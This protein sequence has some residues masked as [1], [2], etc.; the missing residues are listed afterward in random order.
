MRR[1][2]L[3]DL[4]DDDDRPMLFPQVWGHTTGKMWITSNGTAFPAKFSF[5]LVNVVNRSKILIQCL[6]KASSIDTAKQSLL[7]EKRNVAAHNGWL[8]FEFS[9]SQVKDEPVKCLDSIDEFLT[10]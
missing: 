2:G 7:T 3:W 1:N 8:L 5:G 9:Q 6:P 10:Y 4:S